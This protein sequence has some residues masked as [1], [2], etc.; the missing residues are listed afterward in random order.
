[1]KYIKWN[2]LFTL[3]ILNTFASAQTNNDAVNFP[4]VLVKV[5][6][7]QMGN[8]KGKQDAKPVHL[9]K[10]KDFY[11]GKYEVTQGLW[12]QIMGNEKNRK[13]DCLDCPVYDVSLDDIQQFLISLNQATGKR[14]RLPT[15]AEWEFA[16]IGGNESKNYKYCGSNNL[17]E[18]AWFESNSDMKTHPVGQ[19][20]PN[21]LGIY[22]MS[23]NV[24]ELCSDW[25]SKSFYKIS[26]VENPNNTVKSSNH[27]V[28]G[29]SWRSGEERCRTR[30]RNRD[31]RD[32]R[33]SN[34][35]FRLVLEF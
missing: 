19:K 3:L 7:F 15:E 17:E 4:M 27:V 29:G 14:Y 13:L 5:D 18:V 12:Q 22:D 10:L 23:G 33:I 32:H 16:A 26:P 20:N 21:E 31:I 35:G 8:A 34:C 25:Y 9:V 28:R 24:W 2:L 1:M 6:S 11:I 30:S